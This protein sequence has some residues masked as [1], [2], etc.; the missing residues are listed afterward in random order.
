MIKKLQK[1][2]LILATGALFLLLLMIVISSSLLNY[3]SMIRDADDILQVLADNS[4]KFPKNEKTKK[5]ASESGAFRPELSYNRKEPPGRKELSLEI[6]YESRFFTATFLD[7][8]SSAVLNTEHVAAIGDEEALTIAKKAQALSAGQGFIGDYRFL[9]N[10]ESGKLLIIFLD[11]GR[12]LDSFWNMAKIHALI[13]VSSLAA[14]FCILLVWSG[15]IVR[16][17]AEAHEKQKQFISIAG[18]EIKTPLTIIDAD[19]ELLRLDIEEQNEWLEDICVQTKRLTN[20]T[21][22]LLQLSKLDE[23]SDS[24]TKIE[25]PLSDIINDTVKS[26]QTLADR[27]NIRFQVHVEPMLSYYGDENQIRRLAGI[28]FDNAIKYTS[29]TGQ[30]QVELKKRKHG[31][32]FSVENPA[33]EVSKEQC[34]CFFDRFYRTEQAQR[35]ENGGYGLGLAIAKSIVEAHHGEITAEVVHENHVRIRAVLTRGKV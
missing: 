7:G 4:G 6:S 9:K 26:F 14:V 5:D 3:R 20:L 15:K 16:P 22:E 31:I 35:S 32:E 28:L 12:K 25:F 24:H 10:E 21:N 27:K 29:G 1:R 19:S 18:H 23:Y 13:S 11:C 30:I 2:F 17:V 34:G 33:G 8:R